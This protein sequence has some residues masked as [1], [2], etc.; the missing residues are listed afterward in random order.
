MGIS[1]LN[2]DI[3]REI[4]EHGCSTPATFVPGMIEAPALVYS[5]VCKSWRLIAIAQSILWS[6][7]SLT[8]GPASWHGGGITDDDERLVRLWDLYLSRSGQV[9]LDVS[10]FLYYEDESELR[11]HVLDSVFDEQHRLNHLRVICEVYAK[12]QSKAHLLNSATQLTCLKLKLV[13]VDAL[14]SQLSKGPLVAHRPILDDNYVVRCRQV[15]HLMSH[16]HSC[17]SAKQ[18]ADA[19]LEKVPADVS[20]HSRQGVVQEVDV[21]SC[22]PSH[23]KHVYETVWG[24]ADQVLQ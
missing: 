11:E 9:L 14:R 13:E 22:M 17:A 6:S 5:Q 10:L 7:T 24:Q 15:L 12:P 2:T 18:A 19:G 3:L 21:R 23:G 1:S 20:V 16:Q 8:W 4:F